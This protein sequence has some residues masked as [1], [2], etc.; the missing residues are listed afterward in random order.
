MIPSAG[1]L[2]AQKLWK[3]WARC[4]STIYAKRADQKSQSSLDRLIELVGTVDHVDVAGSELGSW[5]NAFRVIQSQE[6]WAAHGGWIE[7]VKPALGPGVRERF[8]AAFVIS[9]DEG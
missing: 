7:E 1:L 2:E 3:W 5:R 4:C 6:A 8:A 9:Q